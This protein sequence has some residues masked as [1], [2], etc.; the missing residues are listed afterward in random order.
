M[1]APGLSAQ[2]IVELT[3]IFAYLTPDGWKIPDWLVA[4]IEASKQ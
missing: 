2:Q 3:A 4:L 1:I